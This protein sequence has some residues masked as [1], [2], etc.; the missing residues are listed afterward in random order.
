NCIYIDL[1]KSKFRS[2]K[3]I[4]PI[5]IGRWVKIENYEYVSIFTKR[6]NN[7]GL[8]FNVNLWYNTN[9]HFTLYS[10]P[11][12]ESAIEIAY[13]LSE[14]LNIDLLDATIANDYKWID[15][16]ALKTKEGVS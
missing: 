11:N 6:L 8:T 3:E 5:K 9:R 12:F 2:T 10:E 14:E 1:E 4:G 15:K 13:N 7:G 16:E